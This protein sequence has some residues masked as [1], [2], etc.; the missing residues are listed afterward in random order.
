MTLAWI[1]GLLL[2]VLGFGFVV[3]WHELGHFLA[4]KWAGVRV[5]QF[6]VGFGHAI[7]CW[8]KGIG[9]TVGTSAKEYE[10]RAREKL[11]AD[12]FTGEPTMMQLD[13]AA[14]SIGLSE[15]EYRIN[16]IPLGGYVKMLG[17]EDTDPT[18]VSTD[19]RSYTEKPVGKRMVII[20]AGVIMNVILA[21]ILFVAL[22]LWGFRVP[23]ATV[24]SLQPGSPAQAAGLKVGDEILAINDHE[25]SDFTKISFNVALLPDRP[26]P[27]RFKRDGKEQVVNV[28]ARRSDDNMGMMS[29]GF[30]QPY[31]LRGLKAKDVETDNWEKLP[32]ASKLLGIDETIIKIN[33]E[34]VTRANDVGMLDRAL[35]SSAG[36]P[37]VFTVAALDGKERDVY[38]PVRFAT[39]FNRAELNFL[40]LA[41][42]TTIESLADESAVKGKIEPGDVVVSMRN[43]AT[44]NLQTSVGLRQFIETVRAAGSN[45]QQLDLTVLRDGK[46]VELKGLDANARTDR[47]QKGFGVGVAH[48]TERAVVGSVLEKSAAAD[49]G[50]PVGATIVSVAGQ[51]VA[52]WFD[53]LESLRSRAKPGEAIAIEAKLEDGS[54]KSFNLTPRQDDV[55]ALAGYTYSVD[56]LV[57]D[58]DEMVR[59]TSNPLEAMSWGVGET[60]DLILKSYVT[61]QR[62]FVDR[63]VSPSNLMGP[64]EIFRSGSLFAQRG[65][66]WFIW[67]LAMISA[68]LA[69]VNFLP[70]PIVDGGHFAFL[71]IEKLTGKKPSP[72]VQTVSAYIGLALLLSLFVFVTYNDLG[73]I[74]KIW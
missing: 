32:A 49:A 55:A 71:L 8:R 59:K 69:V 28:Q 23:P 10:R 53:A 56:Y 4:A 17:Q 29:F 30:R 38:I 1:T 34:R 46:L 2:M 19:P 27:V 5:D 36:K 12:G 64:I 14:H 54:S 65:P 7:A 58:A 9:F 62:M 61:L 18:A 57:F 42:R 25:I 22:F 44:G 50:I 6:A 74:F 26:V 73:R 66:D 41:P 48:E 47:A 11:A 52:N 72:A 31:L 63:T 3:F 40:G 15:T 33:G 13:T 51:P 16:W 21:G 43:Q 70:V 68:N 20:S 39:P 60:R 24:N 67:F 45:G 35:Q 37:L